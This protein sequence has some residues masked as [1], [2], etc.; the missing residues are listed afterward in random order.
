MSCLFDVLDPSYPNSIYIEFHLIFSMW[1]CKNCFCTSF[2]AEILSVEFRATLN[3]SISTSPDINRN[4]SLI[5]L[6]T[7]DELLG[8]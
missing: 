3:L 2:L 1:L 5:W 8:S 7:R 6:R 4:I